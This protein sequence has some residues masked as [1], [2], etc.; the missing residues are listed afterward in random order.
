MQICAT[1]RVVEIDLIS[2]VGLRLMISFVQFMVLEI[3]YNVEIALN[4][5]VGLRRLAKF[6]MPGIILLDSE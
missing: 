5:V 4:S 3:H 6:G 2:V 1:K